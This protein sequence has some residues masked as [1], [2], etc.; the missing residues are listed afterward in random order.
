MKTIHVAIIAGLLISAA[1][2]AQINLPDPSAPGST[3]DN[4]VRIVGSELM[5]D[6]FISRWLRTHYPGWSADPIE[7]TDIGFQRYAVVH[8]RSENNPSRRVYFRVVKQQNDPS[9]D[10]LGFPRG[11]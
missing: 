7:Y 5:A 2:T 1:A 8:I 9:D 10:G 6:R 4:A 3:P 11:Q